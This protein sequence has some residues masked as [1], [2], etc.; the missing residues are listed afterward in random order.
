MKRIVFPFLG[1]LMLGLFSCMDTGGDNI[2]SYSFVPAI[3]EEF[4]FNTF[5]PALFTPLGKII[6]PDLHNA[7]NPTLYEGDAVLANF[8]I[9]QDQQLS[10]EYTIASDVQCIKINQV[11][12][13]S[14][15]GGESESDNFNFK[16]NGINTGIVFFCDNYRAFIFI[17]F[18]H[19]APSDQ[20]FDYEMTYDPYENTNIAYIRAKKNGQGTKNNSALINYLYAFNIT[21]YLIKLRGS[22]KRV[23]FKLKY[24]IGEEEGKDVYGEYDKPFDIIFEE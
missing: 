8:N 1:I 12:A 22:E 13:Y 4:D 9:N 11:R 5:Q 19:E 15:S 24:K 18:T 14:T 16:I 21:D 7:Q 17:E 20:E 6:V 23:T 3:V 2:S 10:N